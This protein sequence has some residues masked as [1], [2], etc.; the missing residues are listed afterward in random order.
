MRLRTGIKTMA[1]LSMMLLFFVA[2]ADAALSNKPR[3][4]NKTVAV[5]LDGGLLALLA[6]GG[7]AYFATRNRKKKAV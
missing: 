4:P 5:P 3:R 7:I 1:L 6:G 2:S